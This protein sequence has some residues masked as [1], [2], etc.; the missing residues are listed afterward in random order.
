MKRCTLHLELMRKRT[1]VCRN[2]D[3]MD[4]YRVKEQT[5]K[6]T[7]RINDKRDKSIYQ[8]LWSK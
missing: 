6:S 5:N 3:K 2:N 4:K 7:S 1:R 8:E